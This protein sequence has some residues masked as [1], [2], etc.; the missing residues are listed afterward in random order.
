MVSCRV[1]DSV[2]RTA[3]AR[4][5][6]GRFLMSTDDDVLHVPS[7]RRRDLPHRSVF[8]SCSN[9]VHHRRRLTGRGVHSVVDMYIVIFTHPLNWLGTDLFLCPLY[10]LDAGSVLY[11]V[12]GDRSSVNLSG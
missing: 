11:S 7:K 9:I 5:G 2:E 12:N 4:G 6:R 3:A 8:R 1:V 10:D